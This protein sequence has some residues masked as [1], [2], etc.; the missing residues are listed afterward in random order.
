MRDLSLGEAVNAQRERDKSRL[1]SKDNTAGVRERED[2]NRTREAGHL[3]EIQGVVASSLELHRNGD[4]GF[5]DWLDVC[6][7][8]TADNQCP[9]RETHCSTGKVS[10]RRIG[11]AFLNARQLNGRELGDFFPQGLGHFSPHLPELLE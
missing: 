2:A 7:F 9:C 6:G 8:S 5:I 10:S 1:A 4:V 11:N 3:D